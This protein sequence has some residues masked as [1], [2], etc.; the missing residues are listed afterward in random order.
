MT[1]GATSSRFPL[2]EWDKEGEGGPFTSC[3]GPAR[4]AGVTNTAKTPMLEGRN[5]K[6]EEQGKVTNRAS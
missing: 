1:R 3:P 5:E 2:E 6:D 4:Q